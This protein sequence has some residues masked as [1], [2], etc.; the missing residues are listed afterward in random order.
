MITYNLY[1]L[2]RPS[3]I[4]EKQTF[5][6][7]INIKCCNYIKSMYNEVIKIIKGDSFDLFHEK[8]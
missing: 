5:D 2:L 4:C 7:Q 3:S 8:N 1:A 6:T